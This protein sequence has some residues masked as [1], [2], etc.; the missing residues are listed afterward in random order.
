MYNY[1]QN[2]ENSQKNK[3]K[4]K[5]HKKKKKKNNE[6]ENEEEILDNDPVVEEF[7]Q[8]FNDFNEKNTG[9]VKIKPRISKE[10]I[11]SIL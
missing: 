10:W 7:I 1:I 4:S 11:E 6:K 3:K 9:C 2:D 8:Y 5:K